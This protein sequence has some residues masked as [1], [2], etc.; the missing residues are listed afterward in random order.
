MTLD[1]NPERAT[2]NFFRRSGASPTSAVSGTKLYPQ[3]Q[4]SAYRHLG[5]A[6]AARHS[7]TVSTLMARLRTTWAT[8]SQLPFAFLTIRPT[9]ARVVLRRSLSGEVGPRRSW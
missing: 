2:F 6:P 5:P 8:A 7:S 9:A 4:R 1:M 3:M